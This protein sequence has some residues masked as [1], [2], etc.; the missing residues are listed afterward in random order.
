MFVITQIILALDL[1]VLII[2]RITLP[3][4]FLPRQPF[5]IASQIVFAAASHVIDDVATAV[6]RVNNYRASKSL[7]R[8]LEGYRF[9]Y[10]SH[11]G[12]DGRPHVGIERDPFMQI[13][14]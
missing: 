2:Y 11:V 8:Q 4:P 14:R 6:K 10:G 7:Q 13:L 1:V 12:K 9:G 5:T 3:K